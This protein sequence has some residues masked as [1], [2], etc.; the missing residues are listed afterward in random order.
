MSAPHELLS[1][2]TALPTNKEFGSNIAQALHATFGNKA[3]DS[4]YAA[5]GII[6]ALFLSVI[7]EDFPTTKLHTFARNYRDENKLFSF[8]CKSYDKIAD[9][10]KSYNTLLIDNEMHYKEAIIEKQDLLEALDF[11]TNS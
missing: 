1:L 5:A 2:I 6:C 8:D 11:F 3:T 4:E 10:I 9:N 7:K